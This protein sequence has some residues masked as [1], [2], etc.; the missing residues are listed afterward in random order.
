MSLKQSVDTYNLWGCGDEWLAGQ[1]CALRDPTPCGGSE[2][3]TGSQ[4]AFQQCINDAEIC[5]RGSTANGGCVMGCEQG[6]AVECDPSPS[7]GL[8]CTCTSGRRSGFAFV[9]TTL[10]QSEEWQKAIR[11]SCE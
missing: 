1:S 8:I 3:C 4:A 2:L 7:G 5:V 6:W 9:T 11:G 10:C